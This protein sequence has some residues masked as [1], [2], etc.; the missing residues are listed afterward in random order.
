MELTTA[1]LYCSMMIGACS[2][3]PVSAS[4]SLPIYTSAAPPCR[5]GFAQLSPLDLLIFRPSLVLKRGFETSKRDR[6]V[7]PVL[8]IG[9]QICDTK[10]TK[11]F[12]D[13]VFC[14][15]SCFCVCLHGP[16]CLE[17]CFCLCLYLCLCSSVYINLL[18]W[19]LSFVCVCI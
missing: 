4:C 15:Y 11:C 19:E 14:L 7:F 10:C 5:P 18:G 9:C 17:A 8:D 1:C 16:N 12:V 2:F 3:Q 6:V 13:N